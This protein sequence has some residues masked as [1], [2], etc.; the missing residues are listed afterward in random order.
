LVAQRFDPGS[1]QLSGEPAPVAEFQSG[2]FD[3]SRDLR[4]AV[5]ARPAGARRPLADLLGRWDDA[6]VAA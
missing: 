4:Q 1:R 3:K 2:S 5:Q 6:A